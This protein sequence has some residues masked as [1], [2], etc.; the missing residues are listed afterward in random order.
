MYSKI[1]DIDGVLLT[2]KAKLADIARLLKAGIILKI[3]SKRSLYMAV[4]GCASLV[5]ANM[6]RIPCWPRMSSATFG[7]ARVITAAGSGFVYHHNS[8]VCAGFG[9]ALNV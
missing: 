2:A 4:K 5:T 7:G 6:K 8:A 3:K 1:V 9:R